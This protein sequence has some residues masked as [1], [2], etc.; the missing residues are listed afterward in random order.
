MEPDSA[1]YK[2]LLE[3][4]KAIPWKIDW[5]TMK[6]TY[7]GPQ[8]EKLLGWTPESWATAEDWAMRIH[9]EDREAV[10]NFCISQ[11]KS[12]IDHEADYRAL[13]RDGEHI[14]IRDVVHV[15]RN[16]DGSP[17]SL[18]GFMFDIT[19][20]KKTEAHLVELQKELE[21]L[22]YRDGL[23]NVANRR[24]FDSALEVEWTNAL[25]NRAPLSLIMLDIDYFKQYNDHYGHIRGDECLKKVAAVLSKA[26]TR[27]RDFFAR[28]GGEEFV[29]VLAGSTRGDAVERAA[30]IRARLQQRPA[31]LAD[32]PVRVTAS[33]GLAMDAGQGDLS[34][35]LA[36]ADAALYRAK[37]EGRDRLVCAP[38]AADSSL[39]IAVGALPV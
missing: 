23:T 28:Y 5:S 31:L 4:T 37:A 14:W 7:I 33:V 11:S 1:V 17:N 35:L 29:L 20:R 36:A 34:T 24:M 21:A 16:P 9:A 13:T 12:G 32:G 8:I 3:S 15:V 18:I 10:V 26:A 27:S 6:F 38:S 2:T 19:E 22:S 30:A 39:P 25:N